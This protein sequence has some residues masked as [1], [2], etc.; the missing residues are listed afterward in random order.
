[1][2]EATHSLIGF[3]ADVNPT[4]YVASTFNVDRVLPE[5]GFEN[6]GVYKGNTH[7]VKIL[8]PKLALSAVID[9]ETGAVNYRKMRFYK[10]RDWS[11]EFQVLDY[12]F[13]IDAAKLRQLLS[14]HVAESEDDIDPMAYA[15]GTLNNEQVLREFGFTPDAEQGYRQKTVWTVTYANGNKALVAS[16]MDDGAVE[17]DMFRTAFQRSKW[18]HILGRRFNVNQAGWLRD[19][20]RVWLRTRRPVTEAEE[21]IYRLLDS[22]P[23]AFEPRGELD[24]LIP[25]R[26]PEC[27]SSNIT[28]ADDEGLIDCC[29]CGIWFKPLHPD[30]AP[31]S[32]FYG[33]PSPRLEGVDDEIGDVRAY[34]MQHGAPPRI[35]T[36][37][38]RT[39]PE[40][41][42]RGDFSE[43]GWRD[44][45]GVVME[46]DEN[47]RAEGI[48]AVD[49]AVNFLKREGASRHA[50]SSSSFH[51]GAWYSTGWDSVNYRTGE[52]EELNFHLEDFTPEQEE[53]IWNLF[54]KKT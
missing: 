27:G 44:E 50:S 21:V 9:G 16:L 38:N 18:K 49:K 14:G 1:M 46:P 32:K 35:T 3:D 13:N 2:S 26:C 52:E 17:V 51:V 11:G 30:N 37:Y 23:D 12:A 7:W 41:V 34:A 20:L 47:D 31:G 5:L 15:A 43:S 4:D 8:N 45:E 36:T 33:R 39:T 40:S 29:A 25:G 6:K 54:H 22:D 10:A 53:Q 19:H 48:T 24:R 42:E 28:A